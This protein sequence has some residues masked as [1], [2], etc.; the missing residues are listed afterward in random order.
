MFYMFVLDKIHVTGPKHIYVHVLF[1][2]VQENIP[3]DQLRVLEEEPML[4]AKPALGS[5]TYGW[6]STA[7]GLVDTP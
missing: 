4:V 2:N 3:K 1:V 6:Q 7:R 5:Q